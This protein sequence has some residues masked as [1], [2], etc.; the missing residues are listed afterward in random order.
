MMRIR[1][2]DETAINCLRESIPKSV[3][4]ELSRVY[5]GRQLSEKLRTIVNP[6]VPMRTG[7]LRFSPTVGRLRSPVVKSGGMH[8]DVLTYEA[9]GNNHESYAYKMEVQEFKHYTT[10]G[11]GSHYMEKGMSSFVGSNIPKDMTANAVRVG[12]SKGG[13][14]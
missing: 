4:N 11:T 12:I 3:H 9:V 5:E 10:P 6:G 13:M 2:K 14:N 1:F 8:R 7:N